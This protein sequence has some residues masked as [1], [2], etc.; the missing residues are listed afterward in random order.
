MK[1][2]LASFHGAGQKMLMKSINKHG[3]KNIEYWSTPSTDPTE[4][5]MLSVA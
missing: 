2:V 3:D 1:P 4:L 5:V